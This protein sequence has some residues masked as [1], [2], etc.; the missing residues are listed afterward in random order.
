MYYCTDEGS[1]LQ[2]QEGARKIRFSEKFT[3]QKKME[4]PSSSENTLMTLTNRFT[5]VIRAA[6]DGRID[7]NDAAAQLGVQKRRIYDITNVMEGIGLLEKQ[8]KNHVCW[9]LVSF[10]VY[11]F[12]MNNLLEF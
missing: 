8:G 2:D 1:L 6:P 10:T 3:F 5:S 4:H 11:N 12:G 9:R 7:L